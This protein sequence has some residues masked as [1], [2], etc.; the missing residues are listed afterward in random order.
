MRQQLDK[1]DIVITFD[2]N[3]SKDS[4]RQYG[5]IYLRLVQILDEH[6]IWI[7]YSIMKAKSK[8]FEKQKQTCISS[9]V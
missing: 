5:I 7:L 4:F 2:L 8:I 3:I 1:D 9:N 6:E